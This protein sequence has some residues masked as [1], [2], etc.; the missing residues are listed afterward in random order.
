MKDGTPPPVLRFGFE[1]IV[2]GQDEDGEDETSAV[3]NR[4]ILKGLRHK[5]TRPV[6]FQKEWLLLL[7]S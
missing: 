4:S 5:G 2:V 1:N 3:L 6:R 7:K